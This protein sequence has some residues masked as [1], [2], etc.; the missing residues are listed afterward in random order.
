MIVLALIFVDSQKLNIECPIDS[1]A[2]NRIVGEKIAEIFK[3]CVACPTGNKET[4]T[5]LGQIIHLFSPSLR[6]TV[7]CVKF[8]RLN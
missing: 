6:D 3:Y 7:D 4:S 5:L 1:P 8:V 2:S